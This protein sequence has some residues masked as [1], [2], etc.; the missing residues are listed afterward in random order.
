MGGDAS[1]RDLGGESYDTGRF[2]VAKGGTDY[3]KHDQLGRIKE[4]K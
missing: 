4:A 2:R 3:L 1:L